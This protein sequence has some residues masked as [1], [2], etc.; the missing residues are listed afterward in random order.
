MAQRPKCPPARDTDAKKWR[1]DYSIVDS[2]L[3]GNLCVSTNPST[4]L[5]PPTTIPTTQRVRTESQFDFR[6]PGHRLLSLAD[7]SD[8]VFR[9]RKW[10][11]FRGSGSARME[12][13][14]MTFSTI[15]E[16]SY[17]L[18]K[19]KAWQGIWVGNFAGHGCE[20]LAIIQKGVDR[21]QAQITASCWSSQSSLA[22][23]AS[24]EPANSTS[25][26]ATSEGP[27]PAKE[28]T[29]NYEDGRLGRRASEP[30]EDGFC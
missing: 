19:R 23:M 10:L 15:L 21:R 20:F 22:I 16:E 8:S 5:W 18:T 26:A 17:T 13:D 12:E 6:G 28:T 29:V 9:I 1:S 14:V 7:A 11:E 24:A 25:D 4:A 30:P 2:S 27:S 3:P